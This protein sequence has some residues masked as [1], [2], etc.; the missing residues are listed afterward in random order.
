MHHRSQV[1]QSLN[2]DLSHFGGDSTILHT[3][4]A[5]LMLISYEYRVRDTNPG[6]ACAATHIHGLQ[7]IISQ[8]NILTSQYSVSHVTRVQRAL[9]WQDI[10]CS[11][12][13]GAPRVLQFDNRGMFTRLREDETYRSYFALPQG[14]IPHTYGWPAAVPAV[15]EDLNALCCAVDTMRRGTRAPITFVNND[16]KDISVTPMP[17]MEDLDD[18]GYPLCNSQANLQ[19]RLVDLLSGTRRDGSQSEESLIYRACLLRLISVHIDFLK[20]FGEGTLRP[21]SVSPRYLIV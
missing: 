3:I 4:T 9:F 21:R 7:T 5:I 6:S 15:F 13:T 10:I 2:R 12:A 20:V 11:L 1:L 14:F 16:D 19:I 17:L 18:E 8:R